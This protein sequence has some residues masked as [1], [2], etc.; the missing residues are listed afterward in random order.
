MVQ[1]G[2]LLIAT[3]CLIFS[4]GFHSGFADSMTNKEADYSQL[5]D[6]IKLEDLQDPLELFEDHQG[7]FDKALN[8]E[9]L[10][11]LNAQ[12]DLLKNIQGRLNAQTLRWRLAGSSKRILF[13]PEKRPEYARLFE[14]YCRQV[15]DYVL[16]QL[17]LP[18]PYAQIATLQTPYRVAPDHGSGGITAYLVHNLADEYVEEYIFYNAD[19]DQTKIRIKLSNRVFHGRIGS[20]TSNLKILDQTQ[21]EFIHEPYTFWQNSASNPLNVFV[22]PIEETLHIILRNDTEN[23]IRQ[24]LELLKPTHIDQVQQVVNEWMAV[25]E[26]VVGG[27]VAELLPDIFEKFFNSASP[28]MVNKAI[29]GRECQQQYRYLSKGIQIVSDMGRDAALLMYR[30]DPHK[31]KKM[32]AGTETGAAS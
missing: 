13:V 18:N 5:L 30:Q 14:S 15:T 22:A 32:V 8:Q 29:A 12:Q 19:D 9:N 2:S 17:K 24:N 11:Y 23:A 20:Y 4:F 7:D 1:R 27:L 25:E 6:F 31:V 16:Q 28:E 10:D 3:L 26:A 21:F